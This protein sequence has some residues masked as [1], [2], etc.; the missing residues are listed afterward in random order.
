MGNAAGLLPPIDRLRD[1]AQHIALVVAHQAVEDGV[2]TLVKSVLT[3]EHIAG[4]MWSAS[5]G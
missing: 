1:V 2:A 3:P 4:L 5:Y